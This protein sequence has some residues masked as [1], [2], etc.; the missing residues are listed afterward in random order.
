MKLIERLKSDSIHGYGIKNAK[1]R[2][3]KAYLIKKAKRDWN[4]LQKGIFPKV[5]IINVSTG[6]YYEQ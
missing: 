4:R 3:E 1:T 2:T 6:Q 5:V